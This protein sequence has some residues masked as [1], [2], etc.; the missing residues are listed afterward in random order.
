MLKENFGTTPDGEKVSL[1]TLKNNRGASISVSDFGALLVRVCVPDREE[2]LRD[3]VLGYDDIDEYIS[4]SGCFGAVIGRCG[5]RTA[6]ARFQLNGITYHLTQNE[7]GNNLHSGPDSYDKRMWTVS[8][9]ADQEVSFELISPDKDQGFPGCL[10]LTVTYSL[11]DDNCVKIHYQGICDQDTVVNMTN[12]SYFN[13]NGADSGTTVEDHL[14]KIYAD[15]YTP[16]ADSSSIPTGEIISVRGTPFDFTERKQIGQDIRAKSDQ[17]RYTGGYDHNFILR[18]GEGIREMAEAFSEKSGIRM[19]AYTDCP[20]VQFYTGNSI[21]N[22]KGKRG[23][24]YKDLSGF[25]LESQYCPNAVNTPAFLSPVVK[26]GDRY[27]SL[28]AY[29]FETV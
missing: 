14:L 18:Q 8:E 6:N 3:V 24:V 13:L 21:G 26:A 22:K 17:L 16:V 1:Y 2:T 27:D 15:T 19:L 12:H 28:T 10:K 9:A 29:K 11:T 20:A 5:N 23:A 7:N 25:C 4:G